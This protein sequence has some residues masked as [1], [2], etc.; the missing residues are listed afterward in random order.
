MKKSNRML[1]AILFGVPMLIVLPLALAGSSVLTPGSIDVTV[2]DKTGCGSN[3]GIHVPAILAPAAVRLMPSVTVDDIRMEMGPEG[4]Q[5]LK[6]AAAVMGELE[7]VPDGVFVDIMDA[8]DIVT[9]EK[10][11]GKLRIYVDTPEETVK[12][13]VPIRAVRQTLSAL[14]AT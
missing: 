3:V 1:W 5:A 2:V 14:H 13:E 10:R 12:V 11:E 7:R 8:T 6:L 9:I 4:E